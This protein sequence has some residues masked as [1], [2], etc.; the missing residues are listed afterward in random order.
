MATYAAIES[1]IITVL[2]GNSE[3]NTIYAYMPLLPTDADVKAYIPFDSQD[4]FNFWVILRESIELNREHT[5]NHE[6]WWLH[7]FTIHGWISTS[8]NGASYV[9]FQDTVNS[10]LQSLSSNIT[11]GLSDETYS[12]PPSAIISVEK[13]YNVICDHVEMHIQVRTR[14]TVNYT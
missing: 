13:F 9:T 4:R 7:S 12:G 8:N 11:L 14:V 10:L 1:A 2:Q 6:Q 3:V 5:T